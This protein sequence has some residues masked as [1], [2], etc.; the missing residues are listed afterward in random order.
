MKNSYNKL[1][2]CPHCGYEDTD[3]FQLESE[4]ETSMLCANCSKEFNVLKEVEIT[5][6]TWKIDGKKW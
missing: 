1:I 2:T 6:S 5:Y 3:S 4:E